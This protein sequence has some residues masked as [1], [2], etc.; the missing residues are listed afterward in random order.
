MKLLPYDRAVILALVVLCSGIVNYFSYH[1][2][3]FMLSDVWMFLFAVGNKIKI[4][5]YN[6]FS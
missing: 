4:L 5:K 6:N 2:A 1:N 3:V